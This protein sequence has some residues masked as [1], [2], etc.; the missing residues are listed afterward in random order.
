[1]T[2]KTNANPR[3]KKSREARVRENAQANKAREVFRG[4]QMHHY[5]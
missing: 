3:F 2:E 5:F 4:W 1:M